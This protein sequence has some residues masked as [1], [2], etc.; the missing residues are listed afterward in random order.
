MLVSKKVC[1][2][3]VFPFDRLVPF[4]IDS[5]ICNCYRSS[6]LCTD[7]P[8]EAVENLEK[9]IIDMAAK[10]DLDME[11]ILRS[12]LTSEE[13]GTTLASIDSRQIPSFSG[14]GIFIF[15]KR[16]LPT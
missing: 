2:K 8:P 16:P 7:S 5:S 10:F 1:G 11:E 13:N 3:M 4:Q 12:S 9:Y 14:G 6:K 15:R